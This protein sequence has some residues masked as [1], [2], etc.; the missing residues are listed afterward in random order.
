[1]R[2]GLG[3]AQFGLP[4]GITNAVGQVGSEDTG[5]ILAVARESGIDTIDT[6]N[7]YG[8]SEQVLGDADGA[9]FRIVTKTPKFAGQSKGVASA[10]LRDALEQSLLKLR[11]GQV[12]ALLLHDPDDLLGPLGPALWKEMESLKREG[13]VGKIGVSVYDGGE[14]DAALQ[15]YPIDLVQLPYSPLDPRLIDGGQLAR[16]AERGVEVHARSLF[17]QGLLLQPPAN[18]APKFGALADAVA[19]LRAAGATAGL[20]PLETVL[21]LAFKR[22]EIDRFICGV[23]SAQELRAIVRAARRVE[24]VESPVHLATRAALDP[25]VLNPARWAELG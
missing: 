17:L 2:I 12:D 18:I 14:I 10:A 9:A 22:P 15:R 16:L 11:R 8:T 25:R 21:A 4:Y 6:A 3:T 13:L 23:T 7:L 1:M 20:D 5:A 19:Q 24:G